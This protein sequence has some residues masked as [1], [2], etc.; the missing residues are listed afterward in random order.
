MKKTIL[1][2]VLAALCLN[3]RALAQEP[4]ALTTLKLGDHLPNLYINSIIN[5]PYNSIKLSNLKGKIVILN[6]WNTWCGAC[7][8]DMPNVAKLQKQFFNE[9][10]ILSITDQNKVIVQEFLRSHSN[11]GNLKIPIV[12]EDRSLKK[13]FPHT[14]VPHIIWFNQDGLF[15]GATSQMDLNS[16]IITQIL[17]NKRADFKDYKNDALTFDINKPLFVNGNGDPSFYYL[18]TVLT[19]YQDGISS[20]IGMEKTERGWRLYATNSSLGHLI[21]QA[22]GYSKSKFPE[23]RFYSDDKLL[24]NEVWP[25]SLQQKQKSYCFELIK[26]DTSIESSRG[27]MLHELELY[28]GVKITIDT[29]EVSCWVVKSTGSNNNLVTADSSSINN[30]NDKTTSRKFI[31]GGS[32]SSFIGFFRKQPNLPPIIDETRI[33]DKVNLSFQSYPLTL[34]HINMDLV[35]YGLKIIN[36]TRK[37]QMIC[38]KRY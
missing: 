32:F 4:T 7:L 2:I 25:D 16:S 28:F 38:I 8:E 14:M 37:M 6:F 33:K 29:K 13:L 1:F 17:K 9:I 36:E 30:L 26:G 31:H 18:K 34:D 22:F 3:F 10:E 15:L 35:P 20:N 12:L 27:F 11:I 21:L 24:L 19:G 5:F 23:N